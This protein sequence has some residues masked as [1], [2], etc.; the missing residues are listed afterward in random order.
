MGHISPGYASVHHTDYKHIK[1]CESR[2]QF[3]YKVKICRF[4]KMFDFMLKY[5]HLSINAINAHRKIA[6][7][8]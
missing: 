2:K 7:L 6:L 8:W 3:K 5:N 4:F 1:N